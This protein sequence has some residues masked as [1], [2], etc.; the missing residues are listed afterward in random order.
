MLSK[1]CNKP[2]FYSVLAIISI[3]KES[4]CFIPLPCSVFQE[5]MYILRNVGEVCNIT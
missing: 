1:S 2:R 4:R 3:D 5:Q